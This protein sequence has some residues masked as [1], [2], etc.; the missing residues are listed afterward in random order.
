MLAGFASFILGFYCTWLRGAELDDG[1]RIGITIGGLSQVAGQIIG[2]R[3][4]RQYKEICCQ[5]KKLKKA[6][7]QDNDET[8]AEMEELKQSALKDHVYNMTGLYTSACGSPAMI[9]LVGII[10]P[11]ASTFVLAGSVIGLSMI[12]KLFGDTYFQQTER[13]VE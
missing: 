8:L 10:H 2:W 9:R 1:F 11:D 3:S 13:K 12:A 7:S 6:T 4:I 5:M